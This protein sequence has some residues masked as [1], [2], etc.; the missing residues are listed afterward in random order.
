MLLCGSP[1]ELSHLALLKLCTPT[2]AALLCFV[3]VVLCVV[4]LWGLPILVTSSRWNPT[5]FV[6]W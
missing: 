2:L 4:S 1:P 6:L 5:V 3:C